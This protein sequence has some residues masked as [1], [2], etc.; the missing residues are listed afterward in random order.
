M[1]LTAVQF[2]RDDMPKPIKILIIDHRW[3]WHETIQRILASDSRFQVVGVASTGYEGLRL[4]EELQPNVVLF[5]LE[6]P[7]TDHLDLLGA[8]DRTAF[9]VST[10]VM[11]DGEP[12]HGLLRDT[13]IAGARDFVDKRKIIEDLCPSIL[14]VI[15]T[16][17]YPYLVP[18]VNIQPDV[19][20]TKSV[21]LKITHRLWSGW[22][23]DSPPLPEEMVVEV[24]HMGQGMVLFGLGERY[25]MQVLKAEP[26]T[27]TLIVN[28]LGLKQG[29]QLAEKTIDLRGCGTPRQFSLTAGETVELYT[30][31]MD[32]RDF[33]KITLA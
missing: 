9:N 20:L 23:Q 5:D 32:A 21:T 29:Q 17:P 14:H 7:E 10:I 6:M 11:A 12:G 16:Y 28:G 26:R 8:L 31:T 27:I 3:E 18:L 4:A 22:Q 24:T 19:R 1:L 25:F 2:L 15:T 33:W 30:C 13:M